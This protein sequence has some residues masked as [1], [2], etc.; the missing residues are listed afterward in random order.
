VRRFLV[1]PGSA[2]DGVAIRDLPMGRRPWISLLIRDGA[3]QQ[4]RGSTVLEPGDEV[5]LL[6]ADD[7]LGELFEGSPAGAEV[8]V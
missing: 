7:D 1:A 8:E 3:A 6:G 5:L 2:A 4:A